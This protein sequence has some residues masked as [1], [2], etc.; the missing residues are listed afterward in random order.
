MWDHIMGTNFP[1]KAANKDNKGMQEAKEQAAIV[2][3]QMGEDFKDYTWQKQWL[4][5][6]QIAIEVE[7]KANLVKID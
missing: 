5:Q 2:Q 6:K 3:C 1:N 4:Q 7:K